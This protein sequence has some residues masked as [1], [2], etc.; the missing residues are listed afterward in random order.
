M[1]MNTTTQTAA[2]IGVC[3]STVNNLIKKGLLAA[4]PK[5]VGEKRKHW[6]V[7]DEEIARYKGESVKPSA[8]TLPK[9]Y[10]AVLSPSL[11]PAPSRY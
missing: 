4:I 2:K 5:G 6:L 1:N 3:P 8:P 11:P 7:S 9:P 10:A